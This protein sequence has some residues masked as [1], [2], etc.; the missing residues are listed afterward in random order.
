MAGTALYD[1]MAAAGAR[2]GEYGGAETAAGFGDAA[3]EYAV[4]RQG[5]GVYD[6]GRRAKLVV[7]GGDRVRWLNGMVTNNVRDLAQD[8]GVYSF[9]LNAQGHILGDMY[10]YQR[11]EYLLV[12]T[13]REQAEKVR[14]FLEKYIIMDDVELGAA[15]EQ[16]TAVGVSGPEARDVLARAGI[17]APGEPLA[18]RDAVWRSA[19]ISV[20]RKDNEQRDEY[21]V[22]LAPAHAAE[23]WRALVEAGAVPVGYEA[24]ETARIA[25]GVPRYG[26]D[27]REK[28]LPQETEQQRALNFNKGCYLGQEIVERIRSRGAV[29]RMLAGF[30]LPGAVSPGEKVLANGKEVGQVTSVAPLPDGGGRARAL[31]YIRRE[32][33]APGTEVEIGGRK[34]TVRPLPFPRE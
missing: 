24:L 19:G 25:D 22:W 11:G 16:L 2:F 26:V 33:G 1:A 28:E 18:V 21:E 27:I 32:A 7:T 31:G 23:L 29:H 30:E 3:R 8:R 13:D 20:V 10:V 14:A 9:L 4:L 12:D 34:A 5:C 6:L 17:E 15:D